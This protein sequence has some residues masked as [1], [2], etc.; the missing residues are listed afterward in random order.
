MS[1]LVE[2]IIA[3]GYSPPRDVIMD[4]EVHR[5][6]TDQTKNHSKD[7]WY[8]AFD[9]AKGKAGSFGSWR[10]GSSTTWSNGTGRLLT[11][12]ELASMDRKKALKFEEAK[13]EKAEAGRRAQRLYDQASATGHSEYLTKKGIEQPEGSRFVTDLPASAFGFNSERLMSALL[14]P[15]YA[16][17]GVMAS[18]Q[19]ITSKDSK[20][21]F[22]KGGSIHGGWFALGDWQN[23]KCLVIAEGLAT[24]QSIYQASQLPVVIA[25]SAG[26]LS[27][28]A[29]MVRNKNALAEI[30]FAVDGDEAGQKESAAAAKL[31]QGQLIEAP[32]HMDWNDVH[33]A[34]G[35][36]K[37][38]AAFITDEI[39]TLWKSDLIV[40][41]KADGTQTIPCRVHNLIV[42]LTHADEFKGRIRF[43]EMTNQIRIDSDDAEESLTTKI[44]AQMEHHFSEK[45]GTNELMEAL[46]VVA[47][48][49]K[50]HPVKDYLHSVKWDGEARVTHLF[51]EYFGAIDTPYA[52]AVS[53]SFLVSAVAR[54]MRP[55][56]QVD[57]MVVLEGAQGAF[58]SSA[59]IELFSPQYHAESTAS[60]GDKDFFQ[61][62]RGKWLMEFGE[63][64]G[65]TR[66]DSNHIKQ[67]ITMRLDN[68]RPSYA[69]FNKDFP[70]QSIFAGTTNESTY[71]KDATG[72]RRY[73]PISCKKIN[74]NRIKQDRDQLWAEALA[75]FNA[76]ATW[77]EIPNSSEEQEKRYEADS[78]EANIYEWLSLNDSEFKVYPHRLT[79]SAILSALKVDVSRQGRSEQTRAGAAMKRLGYKSH[80]D[81]KTGGRYYEKTTS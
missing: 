28:V 6:A 78:W 2:A 31:C 14:T 7:G 37:V 30:L 32:E 27:R 51:A 10:D 71:L 60:V 46:I 72:A 53:Q 79:T 63:M 45:V 9:D 21:L 64:T 42:M 20:K 33:V 68:Y 58:K 3:F 26:N 1:T 59:L 62:L 65:V 57:T 54:I 55:G 25:Y 66:A 73:L 36:A 19:I 22:I 35:I 47:M 50:F 41:Q 16:P 75:L 34:D 40:K 43:N 70:R 61:N 18:L 24:A 81:G 39:S 38:R 80:Q 74:I 77:W 52:S 56:C 8:I 76:S 11:S 69:R 49:N 48:N 29:A 67:I 23:A 12:S 15:V 13:K 17:S 4:G 44:K 5:F